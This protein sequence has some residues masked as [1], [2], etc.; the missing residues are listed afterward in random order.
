MQHNTF[1]KDTAKL[2]KQYMAKYRTMA[3]YMHNSNP[4]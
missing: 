2:S 1:I 4:S 3:V